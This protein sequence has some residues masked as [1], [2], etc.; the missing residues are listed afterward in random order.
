MTIFRIFLCFLFL[1][2]TFIFAQE[3]EVSHTVVSGETIYQISKK[4][5]VKVDDIFKLNPTAKAGIKEND[6]LVITKSSSLSSNVHVVKPKETLYGIARDYKV[7]FGDLKNLNEAILTEGL[8]IGQSIKIPSVKVNTPVKEEIN[9]PLTPEKVKVIEPVKTVQVI[10]KPVNENFKFHIVEPKETKFGIAKKYGM[11]ISELEK[12]NPKIISGLPIGFK[13]KVNEVSLAKVETSMEKEAKG[14]ESENRTIVTKDEEVSI[15]EKKAG[16]ARYEVKAK[17]TL[18]SLS[19]TLEI[20]QD[21]LIELNPILKDGVKDGMQL[22]VPAKSS[23]TILTNSKFKDLTKSINSQKRK[24]LVLL[25]PFNAAKIQSD[26]INNLSVRLKKDNFLNMTLDF[27]SGALMA[28]EYGKS[29]GLNLDVKIL[30]SEESKASSSVEKVIKE[31][32]LQNADAIIGPFYQQYAEKVAELVKNVP[33]ISPLSKEIGKPYPNLYQSM[34]SADFIKKFMLDYLVAKNGNII[35]VNDVKKSA[36]RDFISKNY[37]NATFAQVSAAGVLDTGNFQSLY[38]TNVKNYIILDTEK[39]GTILSVLKLMS[40][41]MRFYEQQLVVLEP[42]ETLDFEE[43]SVNSIANLKL[44]YPSLTRDSGSN[45][46]NLFEIDYKKKNKTVPNQF[47]TR[48]FDITFDTMLRLSQDK[49]I[50]QSLEEDKTEQLESKFEYIKKDAEGYINKGIY[51]L[52]YQED[53]TI[54]PV[55]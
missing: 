29:L 46:L 43:I 12:I 33:V 24:Q 13:L 19:Q 20:T 32:N 47:A 25:F 21:D 52:E 48:G 54:K 39:T 3:T 36:N 1:M 38:D 27:Y 31:N 28:I 7:S 44:L 42:N 8:K 6:V 15:P 14:K 37:P 34:P 30:D 10:D 45:E 11:T 9:V 18:Y 4:Y 22:I 55:N 26:S 53:L 2:T 17:E 16:Y 23:L 49:S 40:K 35:V 51:I 50:T 5:K 41:E